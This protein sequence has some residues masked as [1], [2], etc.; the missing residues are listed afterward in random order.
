VDPRYSGGSNAT[1]SRV[2]SISGNTTFVLTEAWGQ[3]GCMGQKLSDMTVQLGAC[4]QGA[5]GFSIIIDSCT[6][7]SNF[8]SMLTT[9]FGLMSMLIFLMAS[10][11]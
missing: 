1:T 8:A 3:A 10:F 5:P 9:S 7:C 4:F 6:G 11:F 2:S